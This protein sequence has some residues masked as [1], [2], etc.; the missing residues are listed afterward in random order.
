MPAALAQAGRRFGTA[1]RERWDALD[2]FDETH[3]EEARRN[4]LYAVGPLFYFFWIL[5]IVSGVWLVLYYRPTTTQAFDS[6]L[7]IQHEVPFGWLI[8]G[9][10]KYGADAMII[11]VTV[12]I[13]R[14]IFTGEY[15]K[16]NEL[17]WM[18]AILALILCMF[19]GLTGYLLIWNQRAFWA[20][21]VFATFP[22]YL[23]QT[24]ILGQF[25]LGWAMANMMLGGGGIGQA[26]I[27]R[28][29]AAHFGITA[30]A[31]LLLELRYLNRLS[32][33]YPGLAVR[34][35]NLTWA[36]IVI[37]VLMLV[38]ISIVLPV[39]Q[40]SPANAEQTP[41]PILSDW[42][43]LALY[44]LMKE[45]KP[46]W[47]TVLTLPGI[48]LIAMILPFFDR[49]KERSALKRPFFFIVGIVALVY[50]ILYS[51]LILLNHANIQKD[52]SILW[53]A[54]FL[55][56]TLGLTWHLMGRIADT[57]RFLAVS[58]GLGL[59]WALVTF[60][61]PFQ[62]A[63]GV[64]A[65]PYQRFGGIWPESF[66]L[67]IAQIHPSKVWAPMVM[68]LVVVLLAQT[69]AHRRRWAARPVKASAG[70]GGPAPVESAGS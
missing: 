48:P 8:R 40:G 33:P 65:S 11:A 3:T 21:K 4:P 34:R 6:I 10:H 54:L 59:A 2:F 15:K 51:I 52:P 17:S 14:M 1:F 53:G 5:V 39:E 41:L 25:N 16:P 30:L 43:F 63:L 50:W 22:T 12:R 24:P 19:S 55:V 64:L 47:A 13:F 27:T 61:P 49:G 44:Q 37:A 56:V 57:R 35:L 46:Y 70:A 42:Y 9:I 67:N 7:R 69:V 28:F 29:Y 36:P 20:T 58:G 60:G 23:D 26:T 32:Q 18:F 38:A 31:L 45:M 66:F 62:S 68:I